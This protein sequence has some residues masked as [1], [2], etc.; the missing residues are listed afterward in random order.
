MATGPLDV[1]AFVERL[2]AQVPELQQV[3]VAGDYAEVRAKGSHRPPSA[4]V[5]LTKERG[6]T[7][8]PRGTHQAT[9]MVGVVV[10]TRNLRDGEDTAEGSAQMVGKVRAALVGWRPAAREF[11][12]VAWVEGATIDYNESVYLWADLYSTNYF[13]N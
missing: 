13:V 6:S 2:K 3:K 1:S 11:G 8:L 10:A 9:A 5:I 4:Y 7:D 12:Q